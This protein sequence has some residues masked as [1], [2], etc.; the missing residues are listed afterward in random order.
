VREGGEREEKQNNDILN[1]HRCQSYK[2]LFFVVKI[3]GT[4]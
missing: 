4:K 3:D 2:T 1:S